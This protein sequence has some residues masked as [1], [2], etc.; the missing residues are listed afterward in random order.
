MLPRLLTHIFLV[1]SASLGNDEYSSLLI[2]A[3][4]PNKSCSGKASSPIKNSYLLIFPND[5]AS[6]NLSCLSV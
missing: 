1:F 3:A 6:L 4:F 2:V 5:E